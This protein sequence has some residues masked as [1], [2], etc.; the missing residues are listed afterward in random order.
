MK[1]NKSKTK[2]KKRSRLI[3]TLKV[4]LIGG[5]VTDKFIKEN[6]EISRTIRILGNQY[7]EDLH[8]AI[9][10]AFDR[11]DEHMYEFQFG[12]N[13]NSPDNKSYVLPY[14]ESSSMFASNNIAGK[15]DTT[16]IDSLS[17]KVG[18]SFYY[19][20][21]FGDDWIHWIDVISIDKEIP[22]EKYPKITERVGD[23]PPQYLD[24][25]EEDEDFDEDEEDE[26]EEG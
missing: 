20:F 15:V 3:Y 9:F 2:P 26:D 10:H 16:R 21:D 17:L 7:L 8:D 18:D 5:Q 12:E 4:V 22:Q 14:Y 23:S 13:F 6:P 11:F 24:W 1:Q 19:W 25:D